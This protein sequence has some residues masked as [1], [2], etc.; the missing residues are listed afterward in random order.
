MPAHRLR[1][2]TEE[3]LAVPAQAACGSSASP[4]TRLEFESHLKLN[5]AT[6]QGAVGFAKSRAID[7]HAGTAGLERREVQ[8]VK[9]VEKVEP[10][11]DIRRFADADIGQSE[12]F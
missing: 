4:E 5:D 2:T 7:K 1:L 11:I 12:S 8:D 9:D 10:H 3:P 6:G